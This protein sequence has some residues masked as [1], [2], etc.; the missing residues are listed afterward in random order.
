MQYDEE[1]PSTR[2]FRL[3]SLYCQIAGRT[4]AKY[5]DQQIIYTQGDPADA[6]FYIASGSVKVTIVSEHGKEAVIAI[7]GAGDFFGEGCLTDFRRKTRRL[8]PRPPARSR[9]SIGNT[10]IVPS[11][12]I[13][14]FP[15]CF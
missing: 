5:Q 11:M 7:L 6:V 2:A 10:I 8:R 12:T 14:L 3:S 15:I 9:G 13:Q 4:L 1:W